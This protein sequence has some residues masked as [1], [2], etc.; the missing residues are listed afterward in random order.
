[1]VGDRDQ[2]LEPPRVEHRH[3]LLLVVIEVM[4]SMAVRGDALTVA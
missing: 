2:H 4:V 3:I 1:M